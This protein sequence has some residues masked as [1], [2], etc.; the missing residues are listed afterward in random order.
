MEAAI[1]AADPLRWERHLA[2]RGE[3]PVE[4]ESAQA[5]SGGQGA[6]AA[7]EEIEQEEDDGWDALWESDDERDHGLG[8]P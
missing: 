3:A 8:E 1:Q 4:V 7:I 5:E 2:R 6:P